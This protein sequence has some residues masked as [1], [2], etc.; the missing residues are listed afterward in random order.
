MKKTAFS[1]LP[2]CVLCLF[3]AA[4]S[5][6]CNDEP[7]EDKEEYREEQ[8]H[9]E[10]CAISD[11]GTATYLKFETRGFT[12]QVIQDLNTYPKVY[13][14]LSGMWVFRPENGVLQLQTLHSSTGDGLTEAYDVMLLSNYS[15]Q[16][17]SQ[18]Y[19]YTDTYSR[20]LE[21]IELNVG[22][23]TTISLSSVGDITGYATTCAGI[24]N[25]DSTGQL[26]ATGP[27]KAFVQV[28]TAE[29]TVLV[30]IDVKNRVKYYE[31]ELSL[32]IDQIKTIHGSP[33]N[34]GN[35]NQN[36]AMVYR[37]SS[38]DSDLSAI[39]YQYDA[40]TREVSRIMTVYANV[41][42]FNEDRNYLEANYYLVFENTYGVKQEYILNDILIS[43]LKDSDGSLVVSYNNFGYY[44]RNGHY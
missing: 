14:N 5:A 42:Q 35:F 28:F 1:M 24:V 2:S 15:M 33:D 26:T 23:R 43:S 30:Q 37:Q 20:I 18:D 44:Y 41:S 9:G 8:F 16:L 31:S 7:N 29:G 22:E 40:Q 34:E 39:Q 3:F 19:G 25:V 32:T 10:W 6:C 38:W 11:D 12:E 27:G 21:N 17:R 36:M 13:E 4:V